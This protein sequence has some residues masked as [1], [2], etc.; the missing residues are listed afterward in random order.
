[1]CQPTAKGLSGDAS[2]E[3]IFGH[4]RWN[5][6]AKVYDEFNSGS[7]SHDSLDD[8]NMQLLAEGKRRVEGLIFEHGIE[9]RLRE[10][11]VN[12][13]LILSFGWQIGYDRGSGWRLWFRHVEAA[14]E[15]TS[16]DAELALRLKQY[17]PNDR[18]YRVIFDQ[19]SNRFLGS[20]FCDGVWDSWSELSGQISRA[21]GRRPRSVRAMNEGHPDELQPTLDYI[22]SQLGAISRRRISISRRLINSVISPCLHADPS[23]I[24]ALVLSPDGHLSCVEFKRKYP[25]RE[26]MH[27][28]IDEVPHV[29]TM[30]LFAA[31]G[32]RTLHVIL[33]APRWEKDESAV[34]WLVSETM[35]D[36]WTWIAGW[37]DENAIVSL[38]KMQT[39]GDDSGNRAFDRSQLGID[40]G[41]LWELNLGLKLSEVAKQNL[42]QLLHWQD[43]VLPSIS[44]DTLEQRT[45]RRQRYQPRKVAVQR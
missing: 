35:R 42:A 18:I 34:S 26:S 5:R 9:T 25:G 21:V 24:D 31:M 2:M 30:R 3:R 37:L 20:Q 15:W 22:A 28:G 17:E 12:H 8:L 39:S 13:G 4:G 7:R 44:F 19:A 36:R 41:R 1:M 29:A 32:V 11:C 10:T 23:D 16:A 27:F 6:L 38:V 45:G 43:P 40:W 33:V 14:D